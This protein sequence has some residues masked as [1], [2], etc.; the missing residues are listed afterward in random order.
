MPVSMPVGTRVSMRANKWQTSKYSDFM[1]QM[2]LKPGTY[3]S[4]GNNLLMLD[5][6]ANKSSMRD[7]LTAYPTWQQNNNQTW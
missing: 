2:I 4:D 3:A 1:Q 5:E 7:M 6:I